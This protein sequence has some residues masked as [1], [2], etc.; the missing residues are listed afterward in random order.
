MKVVPTWVENYFT[1]LGHSCPSIGSQN[2]KHL[3]AGVLKPMRVAAVLKY[4]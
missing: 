1:S 3:P 4:L 2:V